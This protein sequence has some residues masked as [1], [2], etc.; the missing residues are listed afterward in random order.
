MTLSLHSVSISRILQPSTQGLMSSVKYIEEMRLPLYW[1][2]LCC[3]DLQLVQHCI[4]CN[5]TLD[6]Y[7]NIASTQWIILKYGNILH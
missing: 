3:H 7:K 4:V 2:Y 6:S 5:Y 1:G